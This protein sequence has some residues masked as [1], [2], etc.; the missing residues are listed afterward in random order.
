[1]KIFYYVII[2]LISILSA[3][4]G[5]CIE[6]QWIGNLANLN[7]G[8]GSIQK[9]FCSPDGKFIYAVCPT[10]IYAFDG[11]NDNPEPLKNVFRPDYSSIEQ[12]NLSSDGKYFVCC[13]PYSMYGDRKIYLVDALTS[14]LVLDVYKEYTDLVD[15]LPNTNYSFFYGG[16]GGYDLYDRSTGNFVKSIYQPN[17]LGIF[18]SYYSASTG[19]LVA[20]NK[21]KVSILQTDTLEPVVSFGLP[22]LFYTKIAVTNDEK[23]IVAMGDNK[24]F[25]NSTLS[26]KSFFII[27]VKTGTIYP[28]SKDLDINDTL[29]GLTANN[30]DFLTI[31]SI[32]L[33]QTWSCST[34]EQTSS[35]SVNKSIRSAVLSPDKNTVIIVSGDSDI[36]FW[37][38]SS[39]T[40]TRTIS[41]K[42]C[43]SIVFC[44]DNQTALVQT[45][46]DQF[47]YNY[48][49][50]KITRFINHACNPLSVT[51]TTKGILGVQN[52]EY[53]SI[54]IINLESDE[55]LCQIPINEDRSYW[56][57]KGFS[58]RISSDGRYAA[59]KDLKGII[60][61]D[62]ELHTQKLYPLANGESI[63]SCAISGDGNTLLADIFD[64]II[65]INRTSSQV[66]ELP[67]KFNVNYSPENFR[68]IPHTNY[69]LR[70]NS[71]FHAYDEYELSDLLLIDIKK[72]EN[73]LHVNDA[74]SRITALNIS[75]DGK[76]I[77]GGYDGNI[78]IWKVPSLEKIKEIPGGSGLDYLTFT[79]DNKQIVFINQDGS[80]RV[81]DISDVI[82]SHSEEFEWLK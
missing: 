37:N 16:Q 71:G 47:I 2:F 1:M 49:Q 55:I 44:P 70:F 38:L 19:Y 25:Y 64:T 5:L 14:H 46:K 63:R 68:A 28:C 6:T 52:N 51:F 42:I 11:M 36:D 57:T 61:Y 3:I 50:S 75:Q 31:D 74:I 73:I 12:A 8:I 78:S 34:G 23:T 15:F 82:A 48:R 39:Q 26:Q 66:K 41:S 65:L 40:K 35:F 45:D 17:V 62:L 81:W 53:S 4:P 29:I 9:I 13:T 69:F 77:A 22:D 56:N 80:M 7:S 54:S 59:N 72:Q 76:Y 58:N 33:V 32:G 10:G 67:Y 21:N 60:V 24:G 43:R 27:N 79:P 18:S 30:Q 20:G